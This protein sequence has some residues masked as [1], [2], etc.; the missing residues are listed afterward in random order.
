MLEHGQRF[1]GEKG[2]Q[3]GGF[4]ELHEDFTKF[5]KQTYH[6]AIHHG[7]MSD[8]RVEDGLCGT[9]RYLRR[10]I[11]CRYKHKQFPY[12]NRLQVV[13]ILPQMSFRWRPRPYRY[14]LLRRT[15]LDNPQQAAEKLIDYDKVARPRF[16]MTPRYR[17][18]CPACGVW[19]RVQTFGIG[20]EDVTRLNHYSHE[21]I[22]KCALDHGFGGPL[23]PLECSSCLEAKEGLEAVQQR[24][25]SLI[26]HVKS[27]EL[28]DLDR[29][30]DLN[31]IRAKACLTLKQSRDPFEGP[32][33]PMMKALL[34]ASSEYFDNLKFI[35]ERLELL[36]NW[37]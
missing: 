14:G 25:A 20:D 17:V 11:E 19:Q 13:Q 18:R 9:E 15:E 30:L 29:A 37:K 24:R 28:Q 10:C 8:D 27:H 7:A 16:V 32:L 36:H 4:P 35:H 6:D 12:H 22:Q 34:V 5:C 21:V 3:V 31:I 26:E 33:L 1:D 2:L 23:L